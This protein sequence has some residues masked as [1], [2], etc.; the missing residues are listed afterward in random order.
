MAYDLTVLGQA[1]VGRKAKTVSWLT[2]IGKRES[3]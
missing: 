3:G 2:N 1:R